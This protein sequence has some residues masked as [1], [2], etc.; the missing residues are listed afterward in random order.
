MKPSPRSLAARLLALAVLVSASVASS[1]CMGG[2]WGE[3]RWTEAGIGA[4]LEANAAAAGFDRTNPRPGLVA[5]PKLDAAIP[6]GATL[7]SVMNVRDEGSRRW[8]VSIAPDGIR[9]GVSDPYDDMRDV[10]TQAVVDWFNETMRV[11]YR[12]H[13]R[14]VEGEIRN[15]TL[16]WPHV[17]AQH[18][19]AT[20]SA[21]LPGPWDFDAAF[22]EG[23][24]FGY[25]AMDGSGSTYEIPGHKV[26]RSGSW[27]FHVEL[28]H[29]RYSWDDMQHLSVD[30]EGF[31]LLSFNNIRSAERAQE[32]VRA[33]VPGHDWQFA[34]FDSKSNCW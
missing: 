1:G 26:G 21:Y 6:S 9:V 12:G 24:P 15:L 18:G 8:T 23:S 14:D 22:I 3:A 17:K 34:A 2:C 29:W 30:Q 11:V 5:G 10:P 31:A 16:L 19:M 25:D 33:R 13:P 28:T 27:L 32:E 20:M 4:W 7:S